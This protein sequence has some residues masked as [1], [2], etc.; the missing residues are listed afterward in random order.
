MFEKVLVPMDFSPSSRSALNAVKEIPGIREIV[1]LHVVYNRYPSGDPAKV[2]P[3]VQ[4]A[5]ESLDEVRG[6]LE[7]PGVATTAIVEEITGGEI[8]GVVNR[9]AARLGISLVV[10]GRRGTG[11]I[12]SLL[13]WSVASDLV[14]YGMTDLLLVPPPQHVRRGTGAPHETGPA[15]FSHVMVCTDFSRPEIAS[16]CLDEMPWIRRV[17]LFHAVSSGD[18][19]E[20][21]RSAV[22]GAESG[23]RKIRDAFTS[24]GIAAQVHVSVGDPAREILAFSRQED[25][26]L[27]LLK[28]T[29]KRSLVSVLI[30]ST[31]A[32]VARNA[33]KPVFILRRTP[34]SNT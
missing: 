21:I 22:S 23:L 25:V 14:R 7:V 10:M 6:S 24:Q 17:T 29:G 31:S 13:V 3:R 20:E 15:L 16:I 2:P 30:G 34:A 12:E 32:P 28:S 11:I 8:A 19:R 18:T 4:E 9:A 26:S 33:E 1:L 27:I 5:R